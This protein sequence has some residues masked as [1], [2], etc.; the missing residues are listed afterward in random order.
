MQLVFGLVI[1]SCF[2]CLVPFSCAFCCA[3]LDSYFILLFRACFLVVFTAAFFC[4]FVYSFLILTLFWGGIFP[5]FLFL[6]ALYVTLFFSCA[7][8]TCLFFLF[9]FL[10]FHPQVFKESFVEKKKVHNRSTAAQEH[11]TAH[12]LLPLSSRGYSQQQQEK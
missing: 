12:L 11:K 5:L 4:G 1:L 8:L 9:S 7:Y 6:C 2:P 10:F 3:F